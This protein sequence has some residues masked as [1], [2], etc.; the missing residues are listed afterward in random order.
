MKEM[1]NY[2]VRGHKKGGG[3]SQ[4]IDNNIDATTAKIAM[5]KAKRDNPNKTI[6]YA[7]R[8]Y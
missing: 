4:V 7:K 3:S 1:H 6:T 8:N 5:K 2:S